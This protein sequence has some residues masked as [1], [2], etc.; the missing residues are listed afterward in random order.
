MPRRRHFQVEGIEVS[1]ADVRRW[2]DSVGARCPS[3]YYWHYIRDYAVVSKI[4]REKAAGTLEATIAREAQRQG[5][6]VRAARSEGVIPGLRRRWPV[7]A[8]ES[9]AEGQPLALVHSA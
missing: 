9:D 7:A 3:A 6:K 8:N 2:M 5:V 1:R 4:A